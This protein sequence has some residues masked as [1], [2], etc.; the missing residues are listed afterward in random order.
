M[1]L[2]KLFSNFFESERASGIVLVLC[3]AL[4]L[5]LTNSALGDAYTGLWHTVIAGKPVEFWINDG[6]MTIFFLMVGLELEREL[7]IGELSRRKHALLPALAALGGMLV[8]AGVHAMLNLGTATA[9]GA[10]IPM[11]T[12]IAF[13]IGIL[14]LL[15]DRVP[16]SLKVF[17]TALAV[18]D[19]LGAIITIAIFYS[20]GLSAFDLGMALGLFGVLL[21]LNRLGVRALLIYLPLG[22]VMWFF[23]YRSGIH[24]TIT[25]VL[26]AFA[27]PFG[28]G[29]EKSISYR[30]QDLLHKPVAFII[31][32]LFALANTCIVFESGWWSQL[33][34]SNSLGIFFGLVLG[35]PIG[36]TL[37]ALSAVALG[38]CALPDGVRWKDIIGTGFLGGIGFTMSIFITLL[39]FTDPV[40]VVHAKTAILFSSCAAAVVGA[41]WLRITLKAVP[42]SAE[43]D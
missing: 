28:D 8:P 22:M 36:I 38:W 18:I 13:A 42:A 1:Q 4:S 24:A 19:D 15:G 27:I 5:A 6:L 40:I 32:P 17:L 43:R 16:A 23:M 26:L 2:T 30:L 10:G 34:S 12:D 39:A 11:A 25:G 21:L 20:G 14:A 3:T 35:K 29:G 9:S 31:M 33:I 37:F 7:Y 41:I